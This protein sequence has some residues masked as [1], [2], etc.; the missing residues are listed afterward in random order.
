[1]DCN[2]IIGLLNRYEFDE[3]VTLGELKCHIEENK[4]FF[5]AC[6]KQELYHLIEGR[7]LYTM[8]DYCDMRKSTDLMRFKFCP[9]CGEKIRWNKIKESERNGN[10]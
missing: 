2:H 9:L 6:N 5:D 10:K 3:L 4:D 7:K 8:D 1:M